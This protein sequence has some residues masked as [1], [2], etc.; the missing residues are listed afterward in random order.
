MNANKPNTAKFRS[1]KIQQA[2]VEKLL[3]PIIQLTSG[4]ILTLL[5][6]T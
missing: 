5:K 3:I 1:T 6:T 2:K 4:L